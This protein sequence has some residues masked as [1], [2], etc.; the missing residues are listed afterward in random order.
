MLTVCTNKPKASFSSDLTVCVKLNQK[1][2]KSV[3]E[4]LQNVSDKVA[5][6]DEDTVGHYNG[7]EL[8]IPASV[9]NPAKGR[10]TKKMEQAINLIPPQRSDD[11]L[12]LGTGS[13]ILAILLS[14]LGIKSLTAT[15]INEK[16]VEGAN[17]NFE[18]HHVGARTLVSD[19][20]ENVQGK[21]DYIIFNSPTAHASI[22]D[23]DHKGATALWDVSQTLKAR[24]LEQAGSFLKDTKSKILLM[25]S[26][27][28]D[29]DSL[30]KIDFS[31]WNK[32]FLLV[33]KDPL[34]ETGVLLLSP[35]ETKDNS[36]PNDTTP[37]KPS[38]ETAAK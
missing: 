14:K 11:V 22:K 31:D 3:T 5:P 10:S 17:T 6:S 4:H 35:K 29:Y 27:Y 9:F 28:S 18:Q 24:F 34:S 23:E 13:G 25:Y 37:S 12:E 36:T 7:M 16:A 38:K 15:D 8:E 19:L 2:G 26:R 30:E 20:F 1:L 21:F 32:S 33:D